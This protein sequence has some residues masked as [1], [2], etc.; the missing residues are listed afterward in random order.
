MTKTRFKTRTTSVLMRKHQRSRQKRTDLKGFES[1][2]TLHETTGTFS[3]MQSLVERSSE[4]THLRIISARHLCSTCPRNRTIAKLPSSSNPNVYCCLPPKIR[5]VTSLV[6]RTRTKTKTITA[7]PGGSN[8]Q[9]IAQH[10]TGNNRI[11]FAGVSLPRSLITIGMDISAVKGPLSRVVTVIASAKADAT[12]RWNA[13]S[14]VN[15]P[16]GSYKAILTE[17]TTSGQSASTSISFAVVAVTSTTA[18]SATATK[19][20]QPIAAIF[21]DEES[22]LHICTGTSDALTCN[23]AA[24]LD[25]NPTSPIQAL[26]LSGD[27]TVFNLGSSFY[28][29]TLDKRAGSLDSCI[30]WNLGSYIVGGGAAISLVDSRIWISD[31]VHHAVVSCNWVQD[32]FDEGAKVFEQCFQSVAPY[33]D[34]FNSPTGMVFK[35]DGSGFFLIDQM[36]GSGG[37]L[38]SCLVHSING[39]IWNCSQLLSP[40]GGVNLAS[41][42][43][44]AYSDSEVDVHGYMTDGTDNLWICDTEFKICNGFTNQGK[45]RGVQSVIFHRGAAYITARNGLWVCDPAPKETS[46]PTSAFSNCHHVIANVSLKAVSVQDDAPQKGRSPQ[47]PV[48]TSEWSR[49]P[50]HLHSE[51]KTS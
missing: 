46:A 44:L 5:T 42:I 9:I 18:T 47:K 49:P 43:T 40:I 15:L 50:E 30:D 23:V 22:N 1:L 7:R 33:N 48:Y 37:R 21:S 29:C 11:T 26:L 51:R 35:R 3:E 6:H 41:G 14:S 20:P 12:G 19:T 28:S 8:V 24:T 10:A 36:Y 45:L 32:A 31:L 16:P 13:T 27:Q 38:W 2:D 4:G 34:Y 39:S 17:L 25:K